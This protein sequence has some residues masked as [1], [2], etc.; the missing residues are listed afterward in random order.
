MW[1]KLKSDKKLNVILHKFVELT[2]FGT[3]GRRTEKEKTKLAAQK[4]K[5][6]PEIPLCV[7]DI[8]FSRVAC[9]CM[10]IHHSS[11]VYVS[12]L[13][14]HHSRINRN[15]RNIILYYI[16]LHIKIGDS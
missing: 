8:F 15:G 10:H 2:N 5:K 13:H 11:R 1:D 9:M 6:G 14:H 3:H 7:M 12:F 4:K 16:L